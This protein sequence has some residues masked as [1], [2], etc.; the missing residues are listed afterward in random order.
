MSDSENVL[1]ISNTKPVLEPST[2]NKIDFLINM[3]WGIFKIMVGLEQENIDYFRGEDNYKM[4]AINQFISEH[5]TT[6]EN[7]SYNN[8]ITFRKFN[9]NPPKVYKKTDLKNIDKI[10][11]FQKEYNKL[12]NAGLK[13]PKLNNITDYEKIIKFINETK[14]YKTIN[15]R[16]K[17]Y[18]QLSENYIVDLKTEQKLDDEQVKGLFNKFIKYFKPD[19]ELDDETVKTLITKLQE[20][21]IPDKL[22]IPDFSKEF[23]LIKQVQNAYTNDL[24]LMKVGLTIFLVILWITYSINYDVPTV[25]DDEKCLIPKTKKGKNAGLHVCPPTNTLFF[26]GVGA[27]S[28]KNTKEQFTESMQTSVEV[29]GSPPFNVIS[30]MSA[31][32]IITPVVCILSIYGVWKFRGMSNSDIFNKHHTMEVAAIAFILLLFELA[33]EGSGAG[34]WMA[35][36]SEESIYKNLDNANIENSGYAEGPLGG[37]SVGELSEMHGIGKIFSG[38]FNLPKSGDPFINNLGVSSVALLAVYLTW[39]MIKLVLYGSLNYHVYGPG[40]PGQIPFWKFLLEL[41]LVV[42]FNAFSQPLGE[43]LKEGDITINGFNHA[44]S[45]S[46]VFSLIFFVGG[47]CL[48]LSLQNVGFLGWY[49]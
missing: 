20:I 49:K 21:N 23:Y 30:R 18:K 28:V 17:N 13:L 34:R 44:I 10:K 47:A 27:K 31:P 33:K 29:K 26:T 5:E 16:G 6:N 15:L 39:I 35:K 2:H 41:L 38:L 1:V 3:L 43:F 36:N 4:K 32:I 7:F 46:M 40:K 42:L 12:N 45:K 37:K 24:V 22:I 25:I 19:D 11:N 9:L 48:H 14:N 8:L